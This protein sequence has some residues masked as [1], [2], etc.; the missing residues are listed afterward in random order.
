MPD[1]RK[2]WKREGGSNLPRGA[3]TS[4]LAAL[5]SVHEGRTGLCSAA[6]GAAAEAY[7]RSFYSSACT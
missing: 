5:L 4:P 2:W 7:W 3:L 1:R 6:S